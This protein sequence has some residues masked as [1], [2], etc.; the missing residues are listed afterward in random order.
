VLSS[1]DSFISD[2]FRAWYTYNEASSFSL[3]DYELHNNPKRRT[4]TIEECIYGLGEGQ[5]RSA[6]TTRNIPFR[7]LAH[8][9]DNEKTLIHVNRF[10]CPLRMSHM[11]FL[12]LSFLLYVYP[13]QK[14]HFHVAAAVH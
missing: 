7:R 9:N 1:F 11:Y 13:I 3:V 6:A 12:W 8:T 2:S 10:F 4:L 14:T 5:R